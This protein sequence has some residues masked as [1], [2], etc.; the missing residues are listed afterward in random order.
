MTLGVVASVVLTLS[1]GL[2]VIIAMLS[3][4][5]WITL[6]TNCMFLGE[7]GASLAW[8]YVANESA[9]ELAEGPVRWLRMPQLFMETSSCDASANVFV[10]LD[11]DGLVVGLNLFRLLA[12]RNRV[13][14]VLVTKELVYDGRAEFVRIGIRCN[15]S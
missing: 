2:A 7:V 12:L 10:E 13:Y 6:T 8:L 11:A 9:S 4:H 5:W 3:L 1:S 15:F 14:F